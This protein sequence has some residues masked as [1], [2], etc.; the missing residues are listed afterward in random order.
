MS[1]YPGSE[2]SA[3]GP[4]Y[5]HTNLRKKYGVIIYLAQLTYVNP[6]GYRCKF[7]NILNKFIV[8]TRKISKAIEV[9]FNFC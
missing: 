3:P 7:C 9:F 5:T 6:R 4:G 2:L 1:D 8:K